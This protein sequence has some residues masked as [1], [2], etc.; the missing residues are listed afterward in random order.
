MI[1]NR[2]NS[3]FEFTAKPPLRL[4]QHAPQFG[5][6]RRSNNSHLNDKSTPSSHPFPFPILKTI[7]IGP[8]HPRRLKSHRDT[9]PK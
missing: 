1:L 2:P 7:K 3:S 8:L 5:S 4:R 9:I 6:Y